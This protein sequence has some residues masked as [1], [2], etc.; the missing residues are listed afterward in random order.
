MTE[1]GFSA[2]S[3]NSEL[4]QEAQ[5]HDEAQ[6]I[7]FNVPYAPELS[8]DY[9]IEI[10]TPYKET[11]DKLQAFFLWRRPI[12]LILVL[13]Y[14]NFWAIIIYLLNLSFINISIII[15]VSFVYIMMIHERHGVVSNIFFPPVP[16]DYDSTA[17]NRIYPLENIA[18]IISIFV[19]RFYSFYNS[20]FT[21]LSD[22]SFVGQ[23]SWISILVCMF[24]FFKIVRTFW[25]VMFFIDG[26]LI[27]PGFLFN[28]A[29]YPS[30]SDNMQWVL[31][32][33]SPKLRD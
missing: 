7:K 27:L 29:I 14:I 28:P 16:V 22:L 32:I 26:L 4:N 23:L 9:L 18:H 25:I 24:I 6:V 21:K 19:S 33:I 31:T 13:L 10:L 20:C 12:Q 3:S 1:F 30:I 8:E 11:I 17:S 2:S 15:T 5:Q